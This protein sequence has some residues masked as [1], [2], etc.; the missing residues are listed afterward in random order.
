MFN[1]NLLEEV[2]VFILKRLFAMMLFLIQNVVVYIFNLRMAVRKCPIAFLPTEFS[3]YPRMVIDEIGG[4][5]FHIPNKV[6]Q[7]S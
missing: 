7:C 1:F 6:G 5:V 2:H 4:V 3:F